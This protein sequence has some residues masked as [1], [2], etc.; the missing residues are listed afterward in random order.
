MLDFD[1]LP[2]HPLHGAILECFLD[3][4]AAPSD[5]QARFAATL[6]RVLLD[7]LVT[8]DDLGEAPVFLT[9]HG[10][11]IC[12]LD[13][14]LFGDDC[15]EFGDL[16]LE[17]HVLN[18]KQNV[19]TSA[20]PAPYQSRVGSLVISEAVP[21]LVDL[22]KLFS[23][24]DVTAVGFHDPIYEDSLIVVTMAPN[25]RTRWQSRLS[26]NAEQAEPRALAS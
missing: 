21:T 3:L 16:P 26:V 17:D 7:S 4:K 5:Q 19:F 8:D 15:A 2:R 18:F 24:A 10:I 6:T 9:D 25:A 13:L 20:N 22:A 11:R 12:R 14:E 23:D 1:A